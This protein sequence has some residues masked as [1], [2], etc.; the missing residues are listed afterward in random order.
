MPVTISSFVKEHGLLD[1][2]EKY[3]SALFELRDDAVP[4]AHGVYEKILWI[5]KLVYESLEGHASATHRQ[6]FLE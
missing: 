5:R 2:L 4:F 1:T 3:S 6:V